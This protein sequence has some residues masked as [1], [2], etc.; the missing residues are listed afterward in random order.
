LF[1]EDPCGDVAGVG[2]KQDRAL[3]AG[4]LAS[5]QECDRQDGDGDEEGP[6]Q[7]DDAVG[8]VHGCDARTNDWL[9]G[10][11]LEPRNVKVRLAHGWDAALVFLFAAAVSLA[12]AGRPSF[13]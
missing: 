13:C 7:H 6:A 9:I 12:A 2:G 11:H 1:D 10:S 5:R 3:G 4:E 8:H